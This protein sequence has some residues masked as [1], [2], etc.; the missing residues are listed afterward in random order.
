MTADPASHDY[1]ALRSLV[2]QFLAAD[3][4]RALLHRLESELVD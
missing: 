1:S 3:H 2:L 4:S